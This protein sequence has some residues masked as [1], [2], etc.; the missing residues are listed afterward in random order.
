MLGPRATIFVTAIAMV[1]VTVSVLYALLRLN[2]PGLSGTSEHG[3]PLERDFQLIIREANISDRFDS[4]GRGWDSE[5][6]STQVCGRV[7][8]ATLKGLGMNGAPTWP[9]TFNGEP[10]RARYSW[11]MMQDKSLWDICAT[12]SNRFLQINIDAETMV[13]SA[14]VSV[15]PQCDP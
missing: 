2:S 7:D 13:C 11:Q 8:V 14:E 9:M 12:H 3:T 4:G 6:V 5:D 1:V 15:L 10:S